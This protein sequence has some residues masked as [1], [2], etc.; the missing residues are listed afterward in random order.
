MQIILMGVSGSGKTAVGLLLSKH[1]GIPFQD[2]DD[3][4]PKSNVAKMSAGVPLTDEDRWPWLDLCAWELIKP[5]GA[6]VACSALKRSYRDRIKARAEEA[7]FVHLDGSSE[8]LFERLS[9]RKGHFFKKE[10]LQSQLDTLEPLQP[11]ENGF[12]V[13]ISG[14]EDQVATQVLSRLQAIGRL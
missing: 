13:D 1:L 8:L 9:N 11:D 7:I 10:M 5:G 3:L 12:S 14:S 6:I 2:G 4:H